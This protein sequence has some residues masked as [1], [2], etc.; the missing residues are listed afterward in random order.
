MTSHQSETKM[1]INNRASSI[2]FDLFKFRKDYTVFFPAN[3]CPVVIAT[4]I[5]SD[6]K[7]TFVD[8]C[9]KTGCIDLAKFQDLTIPKK[10]ILFF[11]FMYSTKINFDASLSLIKSKFDCKIVL[12]KCLCYPEDLFLPNYADIVLYSTY[13]AKPITLKK[14]GLGVVNKDFYKE[15]NIHSMNFDQNEEA[16]FSG[17]FN[18]IKDHPD[19][20]KAKA[21]GDWLNYTNKKFSDDDVAKYLLEIS[22]KIDSLKRGK[23]INHHIYKQYID[24]KSFLFLGEHDWRTNILCRTK[25]Q[26]DLILK[27]IFEFGY[28]ASSHYQALS[29]LD[30]KSSKL[31]HSKEIEERVINLF[32][33]VVTERD[34]K[35][36]AKIINETNL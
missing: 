16:A 25:S 15:F 7:F 13:M 22:S 10:S 17:L 23:L 26:R 4:A 29:F 19:E 1:V 21:K 20:F 33:D 35:N 5:K 2:I 18:K 3:I 14:F 8:V 30:D 27:S 28:F 31:N 34:A 32:N 12:D 6:I 36:I 24:S 11:V 9:S